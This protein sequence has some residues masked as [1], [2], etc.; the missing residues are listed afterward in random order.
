M[1]LREIQSQ[2]E[3]WLFRG[4]II[5]LYGARQVGKTTLTKSLISQYGDEAGFYNCEIQSVRSALSSE[6]PGILKKYLGD[7]K[8]VV[9]DEAQYIPNIGRVLKILIDTYPALQIIAT[10]SSS[11][12]LANQTSEPLTGRA[13]QFVL[14]PLSYSEVSDFLNPFERRAQLENFLISGM[15]P[16]IVQAPTGD[17]RILLDELSSRYLYQDVLTFENIKRADVIFKLLQLLAL[18]IG[19]EVSLNELSTHLQINRRTVERYIDLLEKSFVI[20]RLPSFSRNLRKE[21]SKGFKIYFYDTGIRNSI[22]QQYQPIESRNDK[23]ALWENFLISERRK[24]LQKLQIKPNTY[25][26]RTHDREEIDYIEEYNGE[27]V[28]YEIKWKTTRKKS[29]MS[30]SD[31]Y[32]NVSVRFIDTENFEDFIS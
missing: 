11:F 30:F 25:F 2:I 29:P 14:Y 22:V 17:G 10:G 8:I 19:N 28:G 13:I 27:L 9:F 21:I 16:D 6:E 24:H 15:Y 31:A 26:W 32:P 1:I 3:R 18:Q 4:K 12:S 23:G 5:I 7:K 20:F